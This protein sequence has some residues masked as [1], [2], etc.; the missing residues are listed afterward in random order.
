MLGKRADIGL[1]LFNERVWPD[2]P[3]LFR[4]PS[5][6]HSG[7][8]AQAEL[9]RGL[10]Q[11]ALPSGGSA[12]RDAAAKAVEM[13]VGVEGKKAVVLMTDGVDVNSRTH[14]QEVIKKAT[15]LD[16]PVYTVSIGTPGLSAVLVLDQSGS[17][18]APANDTDKKPDGTPKPKIEAL[19]EAGTKFIE[20]MKPGAK[21]TLI[22]FST[23]VST[24]E[25]FT[26]NK[27]RLIAQIRSL[28]PKDGTSLYDATM[29]G[30]ETL[31]AANPEGNK[32]VVVL[33]D[34]KDESPGSRYSDQA[35]IDRAKETGIKL[36]MLG[37]GRKKEINEKVMT[38]MAR[39]TGGEYFHV[40]SADELVRT[41]Q[42]LSRPERHRG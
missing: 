17:M 15:T 9:V 14:L 36:Y 11:K 7:N 42:K 33:T 27:A 25:E 8:K 39:Q 30:I 2:K 6:N 18:A 5:G 38:N 16:V 35:V 29:A 23:D 31:I 34:G 37:L 13:L 4:R 32:V 20:M 41:F 10:V 19:H 1:I 40:T 3:N 12:Y 28:Q 22:A 21:A 24:P 26:D